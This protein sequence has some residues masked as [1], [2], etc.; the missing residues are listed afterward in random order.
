MCKVVS[1]DDFTFLRSPKRPTRRF[2][3]ETS[4]DL[5][6]MPKSFNNLWEVNDVCLLAFSFPMRF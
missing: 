6:E 2:Q 3:V 1:G 4:Q 5:P